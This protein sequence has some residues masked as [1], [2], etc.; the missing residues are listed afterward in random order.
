MTFRRSKSGSERLTPS[1]TIP[2]A[3]W[4]A[5][6]MSTSTTRSG[7]DVGVGGAG[8]ATAGPDQLPKAWV[9]R[10]RASASVRS[11]ART[12]AALAGEYEDR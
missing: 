4:G 12:R 10:R 2:I 3:V 1:W 9:A 8:A 5:P 6:A 11:P 7:I